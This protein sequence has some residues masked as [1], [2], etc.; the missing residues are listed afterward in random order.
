MWKP[1]HIC[2]ERLPIALSM[3]RSP[4]A[5]IFMSKERVAQTQVCLF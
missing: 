5:E 3:K 2:Q 1:I 4:D